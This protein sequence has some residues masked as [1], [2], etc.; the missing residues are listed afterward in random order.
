MKVWNWD[1]GF[2][3]A[4]ED[5][6]GKKYPRVQHSTACKATGKQVRSGTSRGFFFLLC[7]TCKSATATCSMAKIGVRGWQVDHFFL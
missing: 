5:F 6:G 7:R 2:C 4:T 1:F 3:A